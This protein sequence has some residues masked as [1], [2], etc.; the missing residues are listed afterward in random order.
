M[1]SHVTLSTRLPLNRIGVI[2]NIDPCGLHGGTSPGWAASRV[3]SP[4]GAPWPVEHV[5][6]DLRRH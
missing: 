4:A 2:F 5:H 3:D 1:N 6:G